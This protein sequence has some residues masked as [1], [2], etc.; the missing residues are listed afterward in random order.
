MRGPYRINPV[1]GSAQPSSDVLKLTP[2][3]L[4]TGGWKKQETGKITEYFLCLTHKIYWRQS[5]GFNKEISQ[6][7]AVDVE[8]LGHSIC[9]ATVCLFRS[10]TVRGREN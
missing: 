1:C 7:C 9:R 3:L 10:K 6:H 5:H 2:R 8:D 4:M